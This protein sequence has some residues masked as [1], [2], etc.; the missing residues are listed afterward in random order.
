MCVY[1]FEQV[2]ARSKRVDP[3]LTGAYGWQADVTVWVVNPY[4]HR[5]TTRRAEHNSCL[6]T[7]SFRVRTTLTGAARTFD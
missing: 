5:R 4:H 7:L 6:Y 2:R 3:F 1:Y